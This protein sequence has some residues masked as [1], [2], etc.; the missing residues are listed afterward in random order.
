MTF[1]NFREYT[2]DYP[3]WKYPQLKGRAELGVKSMKRLIRDNAKRNGILDNERAAMALLQYSNTPLPATC[4]SPAQ[5]LFHRQLKG[6]LPTHRSHYHLHPEWILS[7]KEREAFFV[8]RNKI[9]EEEYNL[10]QTP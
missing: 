1:S 6:T 10:H 3:Q 9:I 4:L 2:I 7:A 8:N 5:I